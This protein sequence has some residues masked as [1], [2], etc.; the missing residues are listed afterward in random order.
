MKKPPLVLHPLNH[1]G[2]FFLL[3]WWLGGKLPPWRDATVSFPGNRS[4]FEVWRKG[5]SRHACF[6]LCSMQWYAIICNTYFYIYIYILYIYNIYDNIFIYIYY[7]CYQ[8]QYIQSNLN[9]GW[10]LSKGKALRHIDQLAI[11]GKAKSQHDSHSIFHP[12]CSWFLQNVYGRL[13]VMNNGALTKSF[14]ILL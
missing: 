8:L 10:L 7:F 5:S 13:P 6:F 9:L 12:Y 1:P 11:T 14:I 4:N 3:P 2:D